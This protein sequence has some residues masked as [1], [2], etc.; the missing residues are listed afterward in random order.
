VVLNFIGSHLDPEQRGALEAVAST[1]RE[2]FTTVDVYPDPWGPD[3][4]PTLNIFIAAAFAARQEPRHQGDP[5]DAGTL[6]QAIARIL[7]FGVEK[8]RIWSGE[9]A[10]SHG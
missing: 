5:M 10:H 6:S 7:P 2:V 4:Y 1:A 3:D 9:R 8:G